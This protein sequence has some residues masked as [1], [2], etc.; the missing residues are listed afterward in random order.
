MRRFF[1]LLTIATFSV[2]CSGQTESADADS[3][4]GDSEPW[5]GETEIGTDGWSLSPTAPHE[6][7]CH[8]LCTVDADCSKACDYNEEPDCSEQTNFEMFYNQCMDSCEG[9]EA[10]EHGA[11]PDAA[12]RY[13]EC[14]GGKLCEMSNGDQCQADRRR[15][16]ELCAQE[17]G[18]MVCTSFCAGLEMGCLPYERVGFRGKG[19]RE[20]CMAAAADLECLDAHYRLDVC[21]GTKVYACGPVG[22]T[23]EQELELLYSKCDEWESEEGVAGERKTCAEYAAL[24]C[25]CDL[26]TGLNCLELST[27]RCLYQLGLGTECAGAGEAFYDCMSEIDDCSRDLLRDTCLPVWEVWEDACRP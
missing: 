21:M 5:A 2:R 17:P 24:G 9:G 27:E 10:N 18:W 20:A 13:A 12:R 11:C 26:Y 22:D 14:Q 7:V 1:L 19:C 23:C 3:G 6:E 8:A 16:T 4:T 25:G 15:Y